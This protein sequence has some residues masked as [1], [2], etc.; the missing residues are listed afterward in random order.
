MQYI[1]RNRGKLFLFITF[2]RSFL[3]TLFHL[4]IQSPRFLVSEAFM[5][6][7]NNITFYSVEKFWKSNTNTKLTL[8]FSYVNILLS[9]FLNHIVFILNIIFYFHPFIL[10]K[11]T[12]I[13]LISK[14]LLYSSDKSKREL[15]K[16]YI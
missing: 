1:K 10:C 13:S 15:S 11:S 14:I 4:N 2:P 3:R 6:F 7:R 9:Y 5:F 16:S 12:N 8:Y